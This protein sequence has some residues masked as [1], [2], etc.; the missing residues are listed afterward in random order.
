VT[1]HREFQAD[2]AAYTA[3][4]L[5]GEPARRLEEHL[6]ECD[7]CGEMASSLKEFGRTLAE[8]GEA[9]F[10]EHPVPAALASF[11]RGASENRLA[12]T[13]HLESC[14]PCGLEVEARR[15]V[16]ARRTSSIGRTAWPL[17][18]GVVLGIGLA[19]F[20]RPTFLPPGEA[21]RS[22][23]IPAAAIAGPMLVLPRVARGSGETIPYAAR[24]DSGFV[25]AACPAQ[26]PEEASADQNFIY[27]LRAGD[28]HGEA[29]WSQTMSARSIR[30]HLAGPDA[31][32]L[33]L[34]P[35][36]A[37]DPG[38][39]QFTLGPEGS[40]D[41]PIYRVDVELTEAR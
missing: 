37:L 32:V 4:R 20:A 24:R 13:R 7:E 28:E 14:A 22:V 19:T 31:S 25:V 29:V 26:V 38:R 18:A 10:D 16:P 40:R 3:S 12:I 27:A 15:R 8:G 2:L 17:A 36:A 41:Q 39:Y 6:Q 9:L 1:D 11:A 34:V 21:E 23:R 30:E 35:A 33:L 5:E